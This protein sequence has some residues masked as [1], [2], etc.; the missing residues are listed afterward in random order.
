M[1]LLRLALLP[2]S[3]LYGSILWLRNKLY[4]WKI[5]P[6]HRAQI[7][8]IVVG[9]LAL[10]GTGKTPFIEYLIKLFPQRHIAVLSRGYG[11]K[12]T[13]TVFAEPHSTAEDIGDE[14]LQII[15]KFPE[16]TLCVE[17]DRLKGIDAIKAQHPN[18]EFV[19]LDDAFQHRRLKGGVNILLTTFQNPFF[20]DYYIPSGTL[21]DH[22]VRARHADMVI[23][24]K[25]PTEVPESETQRM[26]SKLQYLKK[27]IFFSHLNYGEYRSLSAAHTLENYDA[28]AAVTGIANPELFI[29][30][31]SREFSLE[32][33]FKFPDHHSFTQ[34]NIQEFRDFI[35]N[36]AG[37][38]M[39]FLTTEKD[40]MRL[41]KFEKE[42]KDLD[43]HFFYLP[44]QVRFDN[45]KSDME[46]LL[47]NYIH[48]TR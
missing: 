29:E 6:S 26:Q 33:H 12:T 34:R 47:R 42:L 20:K 16:I 15:R 3:V 40:A 35:G 14:P 8:T 10:G 41:L 36:F 18:V 32:K 48:G 19:I 22:K 38:K 21:R 44:V 7:K 46:R 1:K 37:G 5:L 2:I 24:T 23:L 9:N 27:P 28:Y 39:A 17:S 45:G 30:R 25:T 13:G 4:D 43:L 11:R 31:V